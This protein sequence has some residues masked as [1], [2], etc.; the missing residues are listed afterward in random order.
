MP[1][2]LAIA[3]GFQL[4]ANLIGEK[5]G[6]A[7]VQSEGSADKLEAGLEAAVA[8]G[9]KRILSFGTCGGLNPGLRAGDLVIG[10]LVAVNSTT[11]LTFDLRW[12]AHIKFLLDTDIAAAR[13]RSSFGVMGASFG[14]LATPAQ[15][16]ALRASIGADVDD[17]ES[18]TACQVAGRHGLPLAI[19]RGITDAADFALP[20][21]ALAAL[22]ASGQID[23]WAALQSLGGDIGQLPEL[24]ELSNNV[25]ACF[26]NLS[27]ALGI[28]GEDFGYGA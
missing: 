22:T 16:A 24:I 11:K 4:E 19:L 17:L 15:K 1:P 21:A 9:A 28:L 5:P 8:A 3:C 13:L 6:V 7:V 12:G 10:V 27:D 23:I 14:T 2:S 18:Y 25:D 20:P 26:A